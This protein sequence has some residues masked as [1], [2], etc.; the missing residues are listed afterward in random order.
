SVKRCIHDCTRLLQ[1]YITDLIDAGA[2][3]IVILE[4]TASNNVISPQ[5]FEEYC[6]PYV[7][8]MIESIQ[9]AGAIATLHI[10]GDTNRIIGNMCDT[11]ANALSIDSAVNLVQAK[12]VARNKSTLIGN[13]DT[14]LLLRGTHQE[15]LNAANECLEAAS[16]GGGFILSSGCDFPIETPPANLEALVQAATT[17]V[18]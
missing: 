16:K 9:S 18:A 8:D 17:H 14:T 1:P 13:V 5:Y 12:R 4:P 15:V 6:S 11:G 7:R 3:N 10:C 2:H